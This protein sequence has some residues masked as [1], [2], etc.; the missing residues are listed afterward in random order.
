MLNDVLH[1]PRGVDKRVFH[2]SI[3]PLLEIGG[4]SECYTGTKCARKVI[5]NYY[6]DKMVT[7]MIGFSSMCVIG[8]V[9]RSTYMGM[10]CDILTDIC[11]M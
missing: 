5:F 8:S 3:C 7:I 10:N 6:I 1:N 2:I 4:V 9:K 11:L